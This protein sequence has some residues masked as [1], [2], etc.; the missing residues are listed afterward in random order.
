MPRF[1]LLSV[2]CLLLCAAVHA[3]DYPA[4]LVRVVVPFPAGGSTDVLAR[5][6]AQR[7]GETYKQTFL[8]DNRPGATGTIAGA[9][10]AQS[11]PDGHTL[12]VHSSSS[13]TSGF[14]YRKLPYDAGRAFAPVLDRK[15]TRLNSSHVS[16]SRMPSSA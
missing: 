12:M 5:M 11:A 1:R 10:V 6:I 9:F 13:Y 4:K 15:S 2:C 14:L 7:L 8:V 3:Q 16:E